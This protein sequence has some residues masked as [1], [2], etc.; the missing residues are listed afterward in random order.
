MFMNP[1]PLAHNTGSAVCGKAERKLFTTASQ[2][3]EMRASKANDLRTWLKGSY[4][5]RWHRTNF[6][7]TF[8][9]NDWTLMLG[10]V[11]ALH[12]FERQFRPTDRLKAQRASSTAVH[13]PFK[14]VH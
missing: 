4:S 6:E 9:G 5:Y 1:P 7:F 13:R 11:G 10:S 12:C 14:S 8:P 2:W 3:V